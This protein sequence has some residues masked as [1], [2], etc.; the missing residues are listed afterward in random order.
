MGSP[1]AVGKPT[2]GTDAI[3]QPRDYPN[4]GKKK[5]T[6]SCFICK[7]GTLVHASEVVRIPSLS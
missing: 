5:L 3:K 7:M 4:L 1:M 2:G 6:L